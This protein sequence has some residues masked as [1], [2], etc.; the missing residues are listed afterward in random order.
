MQARAENGGSWTEVQKRGKR[1]KETEMGRK[2][3]GEQGMGEKMDSL[4][5]KNCVLNRFLRNYSRLRTCKL[6]RF[7]KKMLVLD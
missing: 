7:V 6:L 5:K 3:E 2:V 1:R 4:R